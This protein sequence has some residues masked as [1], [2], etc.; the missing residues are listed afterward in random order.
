MNFIDTHDEIIGF[1]VPMGRMPKIE[2]IACSEC[3][4]TEPIRLIYSENR[5][6]DNQGP[7][8]RQRSALGP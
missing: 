5:P 2:M 1:V 4:S 6:D 8:H 7:V 3:A